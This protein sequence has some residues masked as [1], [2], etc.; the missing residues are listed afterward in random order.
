MFTFLVTMRKRIGIL[1]A[2][3]DCP[4]LNAVI[5]AVVRRA[6][7]DDV[8]VLGIKNGWRGLVEG[9]VEPL[10]RSSVTGILPRG[11]TILGTSR[12]NPLQSP[13]TLARVKENWEKFGLSA[14]IVVGGDGTLS[15]A[16][17]VWRDHQIPLVG[18]PKTIDNDVRGTDFTF[19]FDT[20]VG[21]VVD[22]VDRLHST[23]ESH[24]RVMVVEVMG[25]HT[26]WI[27]AFGGIAGGADVVLVPEHPFKLSRVCELL[28]H[29]EEQGRAFSIVVVAEDAHPHPDE[30]FL[31]GEL[32]EML[33]RHDRLGGI[34]SVLAHEIERCTGIETR[35]TKLG[36]V[37]R[38]G[39]PTPFDRVLATRFGVKAYEMV[40]AEQWGQM[41]ALRG[42]KT[43]AV[44][45]EE[46][47]SELNRLDE[48]IY[49]V[50]EVFF[51]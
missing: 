12:L 31:G 29:R 2:G 43:V 42:N 51:G 28:R 23:A 18:I 13:E 44:P 30:D 47:V 17:D 36:Y 50:A 46:A 5:R 49:H 45:L 33:Y 37:Q 10:T 20:A 7:A 39:S 9:D 35:V 8:E 34:G 1:T 27:A 15:A 48:E 24:H 21:V 41:A 6:V 22:A 38:G 25:R 3:G 32:R 19:G 26:G 16:L 40:L 14:L 4:G 11:G